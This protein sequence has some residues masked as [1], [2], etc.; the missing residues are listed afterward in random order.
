MTKKSQL[1]DPAALDRLLP[2]RKVIDLTSFSKATI[3]RKVADGTLPAPL[4]IG[5]S[6]VAWR[7]SHIAA[8]MAEQD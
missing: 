1:P 8:W 3:Y 5:S 6:R 4:K 7:Q 2:I